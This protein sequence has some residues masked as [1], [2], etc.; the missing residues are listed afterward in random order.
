MIATQLH[1]KK[2]VLQLADGLINAILAGRIL[3]RPITEMQRT[4]YIGIYQSKD[5][6]NTIVRIQSTAPKGLKASQGLET[7]K[8]YVKIGMMKAITETEV[9]WWYRHTYGLITYRTFSQNLSLYLAGDR[10]VGRRMTMLTHHFF[11]LPK[12]HNAWVEQGSGGKPKQLI[13]VFH[14]SF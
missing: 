13:Q 14:M 6:K 7:S 1:L 9:N 12:F 11:L 3:K 5:E 10:V 2:K 4:K 8:M